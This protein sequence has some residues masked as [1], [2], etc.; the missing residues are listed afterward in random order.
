MRNFDLLISEFNA[1]QKKF[2]YLQTI[3]LRRD[4][5]ENNCSK[6]LLELILSAYPSSQRN[7]KFEINFSGVRGFNISNIDGLIAIS[8]N[9]ADISTDQME[10]INYYVK[11]DE[12]DLFSFYCSNF[13][14]NVR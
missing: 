12:N 10:E 2:G 5:Y 8:I 4:I 11:E 14:F 9:I 6:Y 1:L 3:S 13:N 7:K